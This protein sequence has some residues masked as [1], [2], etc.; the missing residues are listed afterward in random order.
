MKSSE[1]ARCSAACTSL[2][3][4]A[5]SCP[6]GGFTLV[7]IAIALIVVGV[8]LSVVV[9]G[10]Q[11]ANAG[12][13]RA[14]LASQKAVQAAV[15]LYQDRYRASPGDDAAAS[16]RFSAAQCGAGAAGVSRCANGDG[17][18]AIVGAFTDQVAA[19]AV[20]VPDGANNEVNKFWQH[21]RAAGLIRV[22]GT[23]V[24][25]NPVNGSGG[26]LAVAGPTP[27]GANTPY[28]GMPP[29][30]L[31]LVFTGLPADVARALDGSVDD[32]LANRGSYRGL[33]NG[34]PANPNSDSVGIHYGTSVSIVATPLL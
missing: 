21:L 20:T 11:M 17:N 7:E 9:Q 23:T 6:Q 4:L 15:N 32:G 13:A 25:A 12:K 22:D 34:T 3:R 27:T 14:L 28:V 19:T 1:A 33:D 29:A 10:Q 31:Y 2:C 16:T 8:V 18:G 5:R 24:F 26:V 30:S